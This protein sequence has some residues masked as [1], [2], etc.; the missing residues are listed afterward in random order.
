VPPP[1]G[2]VFAAYPRPVRPLRTT[3]PERGVPSCRFHHIIIPA[4]RGSHTKSTG[5]RSSRTLHGPPRTYARCGRGG[6]PCSTC[7]AAGSVPPWGNDQRGRG[8]RVTPIRRSAA[9]PHRFHDAFR[10][11]VVAVT[12]TSRTRS[13]RGGRRGPNC[14]PWRPLWD[15][16]ACAAGPVRVDAGRAPACP[17]RLG[18]S[19]ISPAEDRGAASGGIAIVV[20]SAVRERHTD[21][22]TVLRWGGWGSN[23]QLDLTS[24]RSRGL[25]SAARGRGRQHP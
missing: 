12:T 25:H 15:R 14:G 18:P 4:G 24:A 11:K 19:C 23:Q 1:S 7:D 10:H 16:A 20:E 22:T 6:A 8:G 9:P 21:S 2:V 3:L 17:R 13:R 5:W